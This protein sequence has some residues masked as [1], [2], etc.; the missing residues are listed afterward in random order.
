VE[1]TVFD[2]SVSKKLNV[3]YIYPNPGD[4]DLT[5]SLR[6]EPNNILFS[7]ADISVEIFDPTGSI[8]LRT[9]FL[10][11]DPQKTIN[12]QDLKDGFYVLLIRSKSGFWE[13][14]PFVKK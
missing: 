2:P 11:I 7:K 4:Q 1:T 3:F 8:V 12:I 13:T 6:E 9:E 10:C 14:H 5:V